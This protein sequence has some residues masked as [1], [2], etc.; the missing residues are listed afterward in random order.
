MQQQF[1][2]FVL[3]AT[4]R[5]P[6]RLDPRSVAELTQLMAAAIV[7]VSRQRTERS[8]ERSGRQRQAHG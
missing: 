3:Q 6:M 4:G 1:F 7:A 8:D 5:S 2:A